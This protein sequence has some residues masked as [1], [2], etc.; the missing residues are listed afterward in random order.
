VYGDVIVI[1][2]LF[3]RDGGSSYK[4]KSKDNKIISNKKEEL[5]N[6][7]DFYGLQVDNPMTILTQDQARQFLSNSSNA[8]KYKFFN[9]GVQ[10]EQLDQDY[11]IIGIAIKNTEAMLETK[12]EAL[13]VLK[14]QVAEA[15]FR[16][17]Q[18]ESHDGLRTKLE[19]L[20]R[21]MAWVQVRDAEI[22]VQKQD[23]VIR[24]VREKIAAVEERRDQATEDYEAANREFEAA[25]EKI[26]EEE[27]KLEPF[28]EEKTEFLEKFD[29]N[30]TY[31]LGLQVMN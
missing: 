7:T 3:S 5:D 8:E 31:L 15:E 30:K 1:E 10:L 22:D 21:Q 9:R 2:R 12:K 4:L 14:V 6:I 28:K 17:K 24:G 26:K 25:K 23:E 27:A 29:N 13:A 16:V 18:F 19:N 20:Q 11:S